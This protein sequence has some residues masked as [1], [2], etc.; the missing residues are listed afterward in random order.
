MQDLVAYMN[1][2][3][4]FVRQIAA[5]YAF[6]GKEFNKLVLA[7]WW[8]ALKHYDEAA[9]FDALGRHSVNPD[10]GQWL[11]KPADVVKLISGGTMDSALLAWSKVERGIRSVGPWKSVVF[12]DA[13]THAVIQDMGGWINLCATDE[14]ELPFKAKEFE[15]RY[16]AYRT[17]GRIENYPKHLVGISEGQNASG[18]FRVDPPAMIG[19]EERCQ[20]VYKGGNSGSSL[21]FRPL[22]IEK[23]LEGMAA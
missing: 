13:I 20:L 5:V 14:R 15:N 12:D 19:N 2:S 9:V 6:Y 16:R 3:D 11:P 17:Q 8:N 4:E 7:V 22:Q 23:A 1:P 18:G 10:N 21:S